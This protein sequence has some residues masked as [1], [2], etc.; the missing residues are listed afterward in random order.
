M[1]RGRAAARRFD[2][3]PAFAAL[4]DRTRLELVRRLSD[5]QPRSLSQ[6]SAN[7]DMT[8]QAVTKHLRVLERARLV[9]CEQ[10][11][12]ES[13]F[14]LEPETLASLRGY[15]ETVAKQWDDALARLQRFVED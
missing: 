5:G 13:H 3:V 7:V 14:A 1:S 4:G 8:R 9:R 11:G 10:V 2:P 6:L 15:L 12:R